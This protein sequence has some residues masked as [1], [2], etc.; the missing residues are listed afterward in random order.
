MVTISIWKL[1]VKYCMKYSGHKVQNAISSYTKSHCE[2]ENWAMVTK[3]L[4]LCDSY[5]KIWKPVSSLSIFNHFYIGIVKQHKN[6][7]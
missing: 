6:E 3:S 4:Y 7:Y 5:I 2:L 1:L